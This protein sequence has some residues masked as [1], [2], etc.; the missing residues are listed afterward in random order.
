MVHETPDSAAM[1]WS[2]DWW[3]L[4]MYLSAIVAFCSISPPISASE[5]VQRVWKQINR[6]VKWTGLL[7]LIWLAFAF[8]GQGTAHHPVVAVLVGHGMV[9]HPWIDCVGLSCGIDGLFDFSS[10]PNG[11]SGVHGTADVPVCGRQERGVRRVLVKPDCWH[12]GN[13]R[14]AGGDRGW[15][16]LVGN[17]TDFIRAQRVNNAPAVYVFVRAR[18]LF[19]G[20]SAS[21]GVRNQQK[22]GHTV[23][24]PVVLCHHGLAV[25]WVSPE[26]RF[27]SYKSCSAV[28]GCCRPKCAAGI[29]DF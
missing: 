5:K 7:M 12:W 29:F 22:R 2:G 6:V 18:L 27:A 10:K 19:G 13:A 15:G 26:F 8:R 16:S 20:T 25:V 4:L 24:V 9:R 21:T 3:C 11:D 1:G 17:D 28:I 14:L 23:L